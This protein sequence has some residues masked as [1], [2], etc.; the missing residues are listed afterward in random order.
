MTNKQA[1]DLLEAAKGMF[2]GHMTNRS[3]DCWAEFSTACNRLRAAI[4]SAE[5]GMKDEADI[6]A[7]LT[8][9]GG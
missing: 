9:K 3:A 7:Y 4:D 1:Q 2:G 6:V 8:K 5:K